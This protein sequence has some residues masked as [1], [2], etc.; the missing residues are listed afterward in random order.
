[1]ALHIAAYSPRIVLELALGGV[2]CVSNRDVNILLS[3]PRGWLRADRNFIAWYFDVNSD[4]VQVA[5]LVMSVW[6]IHD[7][8]TTHNV[9]KELIKLFR[10]LA[11][12]V[13]D[14]VRVGNVMSRNLQW[15]LHG[16]TLRKCAFTPRV[17]VNSYQQKAS[18]VPR[19][20]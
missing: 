14:L 4:L 1:M 16:V 15:K 20:C 5:G 8:S 17:A 18:V 3:D 10:M 19:N 7:D 13:F 9:I 11:H 12:H 2:K 6:Y